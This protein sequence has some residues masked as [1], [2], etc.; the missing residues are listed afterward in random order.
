MCLTLLIVSPPPPL[1]PLQR[2]GRAQK[3]LSPT[4]PQPIQ[5]NKPSRRA[6]RTQEAAR[7]VSRQLGAA[8]VLCCFGLT[9]C[10]PSL[11]PPCPSPDTVHISVSCGALCRRRPTGMSPWSQH[12]GAEQ[13]SKVCSCPAC[14]GAPCLLSLAQRHAYVWQSKGRRKTSHRR[15]WTISRGAR[16][17]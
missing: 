1:P 11:F 16:R 14:P 7:S 9:K 4:K 5:G 15:R 10:C 17:Q 6:G 12:S 8:T 13:L 2:P 3:E